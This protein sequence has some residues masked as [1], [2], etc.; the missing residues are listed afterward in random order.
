MFGSLQYFSS[1]RKWCV[2]NEWT[3]NRLPVFVQRLRKKA[4]TPD[5][6]QTC[7][8]LWSYR[9]VRNAVYTSELLTKFA[10]FQWDSFNLNMKLFT[11]CRLHRW[12]SMKT[13]INQEFLETLRQVHHFKDSSRSKTFVS[14]LLKSRD[15][16]HMERL[17]NRL[18]RLTV[19]IYSF[20]RLPVTWYW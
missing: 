16:K 8:W 4:K 17:W 10:I 9:M 6:I 11:N 14:K 20:W 1:E 18:W 12:K 15:S 13:T 3:G 7:F 19:K 5:M 2:L